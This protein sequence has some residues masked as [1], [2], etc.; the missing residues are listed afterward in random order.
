MDDLTPDQQENL[1]E[2][3]RTLECELREL[4][5]SS[6]EGARPVKLDQPIG[7]VSRIDA[8]QQQS[9]ASATRSAMQLRLRQVGSALRR[10]DEDEYGLCV[11]CGE[12]IGFAR[13][14]VKPEAP[15]CIGCQ[16]SREQRS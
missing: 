12:A 5:E 6:A 11:A 15:L 8:I 14:S 1:H 3:L 13:L 9:M 2:R 10:L 7:R 4:L 16:S